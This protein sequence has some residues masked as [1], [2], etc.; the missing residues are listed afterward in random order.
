MSDIY[1]N[2][3]MDALRVTFEDM[4]FEIETLKDDLTD[5]DYANLELY[6]EA[7]EL[8][9][10]LGRLREMYDQDMFDAAE[11]YVELERSYN[12]LADKYIDLHDWIHDEDFVDILFEK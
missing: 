5:A 9:A 12:Q 6:A 11:D 2:D 10:E 3:D 4:M 7:N 8:E 1:Q